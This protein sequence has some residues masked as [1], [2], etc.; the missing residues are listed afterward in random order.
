VRFHF[1][2]SKEMVMG[3]S[4]PTIDVEENFSEGKEN[5]VG[6]VYLGYEAS[7]SR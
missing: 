3:V 6:L 1:F 2:P 7:C 4:R 5:A